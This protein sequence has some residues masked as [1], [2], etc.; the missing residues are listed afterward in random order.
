MKIIV[1]RL[2][3]AYTTQLAGRAHHSRRSLDL[4][5]FDRHTLRCKLGIHF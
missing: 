2:S 3:L 5:N 4:E 1:A